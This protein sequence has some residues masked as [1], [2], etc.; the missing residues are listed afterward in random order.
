MAAWVYILK[1]ADGSYYTGCTTDLLQRFGQHQSG[2]LG[3]YTSTRRPLEMVWSSEFDDINQAISLEQR[4]KR[5][6]RAKKEAVIRGDWAALPGLS[7]R[8]FRPSR[9]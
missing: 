3:G 1:C 7:A 6:S 4:L 8:G 2:E 9:L 5:W